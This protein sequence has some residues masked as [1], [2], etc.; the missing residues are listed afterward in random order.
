MAGKKLKTYQLKLALPYQPYMAEVRI[1]A[2]GKD[3]SET[4]PIANEISQNTGC[5]VGIFDFS[6]RKTKAN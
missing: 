6:Y 3:S 2:V 1:I 5:S 4:Y